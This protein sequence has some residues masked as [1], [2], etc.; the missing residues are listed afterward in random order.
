[1]PHY[2]HYIISTYAQ[3]NHI[4]MESSLLY[5]TWENSW[6]T[7]QVKLLARKHLVNELQLVHMPNTFSAYL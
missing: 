3:C 1:M 6:Q 7:V 2:F 4:A 5:H